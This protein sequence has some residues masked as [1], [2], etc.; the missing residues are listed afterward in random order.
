MHPPPHTHTRTHPHTV[1]HTCTHTNIEICRYIDIQW[2]DTRTA[3]HT[4]I[5]TYRNTSRYNHS[6]KIQ[7]RKWWIKWQCLTVAGCAKYDSDNK[8][9]I[10]FKPLNGCLFSVT[11]AS[12][13]A[14]YKQLKQNQ[15]EK[16]I[17]WIAH[18]NLHGPNSRN[19]SSQI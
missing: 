13:D 18:W 7:T 1:I 17:C 14:F 15:R 3:M 16:I 10:T 19:V 4:Y 5:H 11:G 2:T 6:K 8:I 12:L 9:L